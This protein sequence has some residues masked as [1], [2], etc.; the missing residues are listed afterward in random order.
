MAKKGVKTAKSSPSTSSTPT[1]EF[2]STAKSL[3][4]TLSSSSTISQSTLTSILELKRLSRSSLAALKVKEDKLTE[5]KKKVESEGLS[6]QNLLYEK[7]HLV[8]EI[9][10]RREGGRETG[11]KCHA[12]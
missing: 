12:I 3:L 2:I 8:R 6:L 5:A 11:D 10:V 1:S 7:Q 9:Q 4:S